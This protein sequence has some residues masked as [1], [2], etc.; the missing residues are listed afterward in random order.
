MWYVVTGEEPMRIVAFLVGIALMG[1]LARGQSVGSNQADA[2][3]ALVRR[4]FQAFEQGQVKTL[5]EVFDP[6]GPIHTPRGKVLLQDG[7]FTDLKDSCPMCARLSNRKIT[8]DLIVAEGDMV[9][10][11]STWGGRYSGTARG[12]TVAD[13]DV[14]VTYTNFYRIASGKIAENWYLTDSLS[15]AEQLGMKLVPGDAGK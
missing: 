11:R 5:N 8:I 15:L 1:F 10:V 2:N 14:S 13:K 4:A 9:A 12:V 3:R 7:P 6:K